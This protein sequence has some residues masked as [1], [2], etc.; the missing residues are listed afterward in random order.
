MKSIVRKDGTGEEQ[1]SFWCPGCNDMKTVPSKR[2]N[3]NGDLEKPTLSPSILQRTGPFP[4]GHTDICHC[5]VKDGNI[6]FCGDCTHDKRG[7]MP[8]PNIEDIIDMTVLPDGG[9]TW[10]R[11]AAAQ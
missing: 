7:V 3:W 11:K 4:D 10:T 2:W 9:L 5:F 6:E 1:I 8:L